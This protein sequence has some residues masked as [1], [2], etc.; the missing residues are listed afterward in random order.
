MKRPQRIGKIKDGLYL[1]CPRCLKNSCST[2]TSPSN[3]SVACSSF[4]VASGTSV[5]QCISDPTM[6]NPVI[7]HVIELYSVSVLLL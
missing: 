6:V 1:L 7:F 4:P 5:L 2:S 3:L